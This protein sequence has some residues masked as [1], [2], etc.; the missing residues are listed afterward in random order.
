MKVLTGL[1]AVASATT[2]VIATVG[3]AATKVPPQNGSGMHAAPAAVPTPGVV[4]AIASVNL[5]LGSEHSIFRNGF[6]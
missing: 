4:G 1:L 5:I 2:F 6:E 3:A